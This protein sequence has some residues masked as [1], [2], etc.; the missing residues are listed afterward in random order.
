MKERNRI[1]A[2]LLTGA[3]VAGSLTGCG[4]SASTDGGVTDTTATTEAA[5]AATTEAA[6]GEE[7]VDLSAMS[8]DELSSYLYDENLGEFYELYSEAKEE[9]ENLSLRYAKMAQAEAKLLE[10]GVL[11][12]N[13]TRGGT[14]A[15][16]RVAPGSVTDTLWGNDAYRLHNAIVTTELIKASDIT[17]M[18]EKREELK[19]TGTYREWAISYLEEQGYELSDS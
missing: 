11:L 9:V 2:V 12:P 18:K 15:I 6:T 13:D 14:Y 8:Y 5:D 7:S 17:T 10:S 19:G 4:S 16:T 3:M 1:L